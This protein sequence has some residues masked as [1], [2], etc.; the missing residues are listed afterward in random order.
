MLNAPPR[1][2]R[3]STLKRFSV[4]LLALSLLFLASG[5]LQPI[6]PPSPPAMQLADAS[7]NRLLVL[8]VDGNVFTIK[9]DGTSRLQLT[10]DASAAHFY[11]QPTWSPT[12][13]RIAW[14]EINSQPDGAQGALL[15]AVADGSGRTR[16]DL[17]YPPF[18][19]HWSPDGTQLAYLSNWPGA[20][21]QTI[22]LRLMDMAG[23]DVG[24]KILGVGQPFYF[25]WSPDSTRLL[26]HVA[27]RHLGLL[28]LDGQEHVIT[29]RTASFA[30]PQWSSDGRLLY[31][32]HTDDT[33][34]LVLAD[35]SG[36]IEQVITFFQGDVRTA[37]SLSPSGNLVAYTET[38]APVSVNSFGPL[39]IFDLVTEEFE[40]LAVDPVIAF[41][42]SP[43]ADQLLFMSA[44][45]EDRQPWLRLQ[46][47]D[48][49][50]RRDLGRYIPSGIFFNQY[51]PFSDQ[52]AQNMR[53]WAPDGSAIV[54][55]GEGE[56][57]RRG[58]WVRNLDASEPRFVT[59][60]L[61][62]T[63]SPR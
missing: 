8:G 44:A 3:R 61:L 37:F 35:A 59:E 11:A 38:D 46:V 15:T 33:P 55:A 42:W 29:E 47:W 2:L 25:S 58:V 62:A 39:F 5:C 19:L 51:L 7:S 20:G 16:T 22:A 31:S 4:Q 41:F 50:Q 24:G 34:Q 26:T 36:A 60:G 48:G 28:A 63:W 17:L 30:A 6:Q 52:Y 56:N 57:G 40:Q 27:N 32:I 9:P 23:G 54:Y 21:Q 18:Y 12:G 13:E 45:F 49:Q 53:F 14:A 43:V 10:D 1:P